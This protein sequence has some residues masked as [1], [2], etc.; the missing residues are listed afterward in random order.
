M[1]AEEADLSAGPTQSDATSNNPESTTA[2]RQLT[3][4]DVAL[5]LVR[6][7]DP[8]TS[9]AAAAVVKPRLNETRLV[10]LDHLARHVHDGL[11]DHELSA[12]TE[13]VL[14]SAAKRRG[15]LCKLGYVEE[16]GNRR[17]S[18]SGVPSLV[19]RV[20][21]RGYRLWLDLNGAEG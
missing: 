13:M 9:R 7:S 16:A 3:L 8:A 17:P 19:W 20:S 14:S 10:V 12:S 11:T 1:G 15:D 21:Q 18:P 5:P 6:A 2:L 4:D